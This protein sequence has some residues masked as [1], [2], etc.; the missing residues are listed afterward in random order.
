MSIID[1][2]LV[3]ISS[4]IVFKHEKGKDFWF[5]VRD[6]DEDEWKFPR[7]A[8]RKGESSVRAGIRMMGEQGSMTIRMIEEAGRAGG[9]TTVNEKTLPQ[10]HIYYVAKLVSESG[11][12]VGFDEFEWLEYAKASRKFKS[13]RE[14]QMLQSARKE[15]EKWRKK[16][17]K[18]IKKASE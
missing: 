1:K 9:V 8:V 6:E 17:A 7:T 12:A 13:K 2:N 15:V 11:D 5:V 4:V 10:R 16:K 3:L 18:K 14:R